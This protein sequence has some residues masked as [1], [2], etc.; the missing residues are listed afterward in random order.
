MGL[1]VLRIK[2]FM[3]NAHF[4]VVH[5]N[6]PR[7]TYPVPPYSTVI[8]FLAN[9]LGNV[10]MIEKMVSGELVLGVLA[11]H[12]YV[13]REYTWLRNLSFE[14]HLGRHVTAEN[15]TW[16]GVA[17]HPGGQSPVVVE[18]LNEVTV[19]IY[20]YHAEPGILEAI[21]QNAHR[22]EKWFS[23]LHLGRSE[24][25][26]AVETVGMV[27]LK[28]S[29]LAADMSETGRYFQWMPFPDSAFGVGRHISGQEYCELYNYKTQNPAVLV[30]SLY[31]LVE[32]HLGGGRTG[33]IRNFK[34]IPARLTDSQIPFLDSFKLPVLFTDPENFVAVYL[35]RIKPV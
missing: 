27:E 9:I 14:Q 32:A 35:V 8:G 11:Q 19:W 12:E 5:S 20:V 30:T 4:R 1:K 15:R 33:V 7:K 17:E 29:N 34:Y 21:L 2:V 23:H 26:A 16:Q 13:T 10:E 24:D 18:V 3:P 28:T 22:P 6:N 31:K 25:W